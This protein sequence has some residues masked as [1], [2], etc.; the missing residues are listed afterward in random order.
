MVLCIPPL[1]QPPAMS[2]PSLISI[3]DSQWTLPLPL[4]PFPPFHSAFPPLLLLSPSGM[5]MCVSVYETTWLWCITLPTT[6]ISLLNHVHSGHCLKPH[7]YHALQH[8]KR[9][10]PNYVLLMVVLLLW[11]D[12]TSVGCFAARWRILFP[13]TFAFPSLHWDRTR[14]LLPLHC[15]RLPLRCRYAARFRRATAPGISV[16]KSFLPFSYSGSAWTWRRKGGRYYLLTP[17]PLHCGSAATTH[18][19]ALNTPPPPPP[20]LRTA[21]AARTTPCPYLPT[22]PVFGVCYPGRTKHPLTPHACLPLN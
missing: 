19:R 20:L 12:S 17:A 16:P 14:R 8:R 6:T 21:A 5:H 3:W 2:P 10:L 18:A 13:G 11:L 22:L 4:S 9:N 7:I 1:L 15:T